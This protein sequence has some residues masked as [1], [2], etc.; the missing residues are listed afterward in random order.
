MQMIQDDIRSVS[1]T[2]Q[3]SDWL[4]ENV[5]DNYPRNIWRSNSITGQ[6]FQNYQ[7]AIISAD[8]YSDQYGGSNAIYL[9]N[10][11]ATTGTITIRN[12]SDTADI[13]SAKDITFVGTNF[14]TF[15]TQKY[16]ETYYESWY[17]FEY[18]SVDVKAKINL[19]TTRVTDLVITNGGSG[20]SSGTLSATSG[21]GSGFFGTYEVDSSGAISSVHIVDGGSAYT[22]Q[23]SILPSSTSGSGAIISAYSRLKLGILRGGRAKEFRNPEYGLLEG[24]TD[25]SISKKY[26]NGSEYYKQRDVVRTFSGQLLIEL[27]SVSDYHS[28]L[29]QSRRTPFA[30]NLLN[31][32]ERGILFGRMTETPNSVR[33]YRNSMRSNFVIEEV[34]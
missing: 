4:I 11:N 34:L 16:L 6:L 20:Y 31:F 15:L 19:T 9:G 33:V 32:E 5:L 27:D 7:T 26:H 22:S 8:I 28:L 13:I 14:T 18:Q 10:T 12:L 17:N 25:Y 30:W 21:G 3:D 29:K 24:F 23:P 2:R 1:S